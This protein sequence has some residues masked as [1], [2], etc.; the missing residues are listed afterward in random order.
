MLIQLLTACQR[1][2]SYSILGCLAGY[3]ETRWVSRKGDPRPLGT[4]NNHL[5]ARFL[6]WMNF[7]DPLPYTRRFSKSIRLKLRR[8]PKLL[9]VPL[10]ARTIS[11]GGNDVKLEVSGAKF[12]IDE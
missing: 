4:S 9:E 8:K 11:G 5:F 1:V 7:C 12:S 6:R 2:N 10:C 3:Q